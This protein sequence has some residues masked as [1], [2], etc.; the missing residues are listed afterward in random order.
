MSST[1][2]DDYIDETVALRPQ[3]LASSST[4]T[5]FQRLP[6]TLGDDQQ[7]LGSSRLRALREINATER[8]R[9]LR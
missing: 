9:V 8:T 4:T 6:R 1:K 2:T 7:R 3:H 5:W